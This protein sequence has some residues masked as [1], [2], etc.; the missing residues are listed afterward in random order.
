ME[1]NYLKVGVGN[2][3]GLIDDNFGVGI[4]YDKNGTSSWTTFDVLKPGTPFQFNAIGVN[5]QWASSGYSSGNNFSATTTDSSSGTLNATTTTGS[6]SDLNYTQYLYF[7]DNS[8]VI[9][10]KVTL[11]NSTR[12]DLSNLAFAT[13]FDPD[14]DVYAGGGYETTNTIGSDRVVAYAPVTQWGVAIVGDG[15]KSVSSSWIENP[16]D[17][18]VGM[19]DG[20]GDNTIAMAWGLGS[21]GA[22]QS[23]EINFD[24][25]LGTDSSGHTDPVPEPTTIILFGTGLIGLAAA[26]RR[27]K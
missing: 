5:G 18:F 24:Y 1:G 20:N 9:H 6:Y 8:G 26:S 25:A 12:S 2:S 14:Q 7:D 16:Y 3:G 15:T 22:G 4:D 21:L 23:W 19:D 17:L 10:F 13:S 11:T 27:K